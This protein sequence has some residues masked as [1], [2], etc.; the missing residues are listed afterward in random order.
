MAALHLRP[1][2]E[3]SGPG[4]VR[5]GSRL[6]PRQRVQAVTDRDPHQLVPRRVDLDLV[7]A[8]AE[9]VVG[10]EVRRVRVGLEAPVDRL[11]GPGQATELVDQVVGPGA[12]FAL[13]GL[14]EGRVGLE[15]VVIDERRRLVGVDSVSH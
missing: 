7:D 12:A 13:Q 3:S 10:A 15:D 11:L 9:A 4:G 14:A 5:A 8:L 6:P 2:V 1:D